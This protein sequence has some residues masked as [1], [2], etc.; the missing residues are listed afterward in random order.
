MEAFLECIAETIIFLCIA[1]Y[2]LYNKNKK[3]IKQSHLY[4]TLPCSA[5]ND[6]SSSVPG[7]KTL[8]RLKTLGVEASWLSTAFLSNG[9]LK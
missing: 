7:D 5:V 4:Q 2:V 1:F 3:E 6:C 9:V 8:Q